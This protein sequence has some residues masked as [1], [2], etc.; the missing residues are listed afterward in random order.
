M[1]MSAFWG[2]LIMA[3]NIVLRIA[4]PVYL[5]QQAKQRRLALPWL[6]IVFGV[7]EPV[8]SVM[9]YYAAVYLFKER[10]KG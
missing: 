7:F 10:V 5:Y 9:L 2:S 8:V 3:L 1:T 6:W 4:I